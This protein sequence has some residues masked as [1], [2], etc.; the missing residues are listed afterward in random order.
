[1]ISWKVEPSDFRRRRSVVGET[2]SWA[3]AASR[4][5]SAPPPTA[6][7]LRIRS[8]RL[9]IATISLFVAGIGIMNI[10]LV[11][12]TERTREIG[13]RK[14]VGARRGDIFVQFLTEAV[15]LS[16]LGGLIGIGISWI[17]CA[18]IARYSVLTPQINVSI[19]AMALAVCSCVGII[20]G[21]TPAVRASRLDP[22]EALRHE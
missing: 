9:L 22:I 18:A 11:T 7:R 19:V 13:V 3:E 12:V 21:V 6:I 14:T 20:F 17:I 1:L 2:R 10:M 5:I 4:S 16:L 8:D 15:V